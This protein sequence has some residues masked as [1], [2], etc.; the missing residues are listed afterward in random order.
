[1]IHVMAARVGAYYIWPWNGRI[2]VILIACRTYYYTR[3]EVNLMENCN[4]TSTDETIHKRYSAECFNKVWEF[5][6]KKDRS[7]EDEEEMLRLAMTSHWH[8][9][10]RSDYAPDKAS[11]AYWQI[12]RVFAL[13]E[14]ADNARRYAKRSLGVLENSDVDP[15]FVGYAHEAVSYTH[16]RAHET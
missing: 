7:P 9:T 4:Q 13:M 10:Q 8:W 11:V 15:F 12:S 5:I 6:D 14:Q 1:M 16:L 3:L 2:F